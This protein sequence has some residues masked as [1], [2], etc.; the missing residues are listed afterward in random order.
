MNFEYTPPQTQLEELLGGHRC[1]NIFGPIEPGDDERFVS[2]L[3]QSEIPPRTDVYI[4]SSGGDVEAALNIG[5]II[6][7]GWLS[8][9]VGQYVLDQ[10][11]PSDP[12]TEHLKPRRFVVGSC[13]SS[14]TL[15]FLGGRLRYLADGSKF[16]VHQFSFKNP[17]GDNVARSQILSS[18]IARF[19]SDMGIDTRFLEI[20]SSTESIGIR[21]ISYSDLSDLNIVTGGETDVIWSIIARNKII[22][23]RGERDSVYGHQ[24]IIIGFAKGAGFFIHAVIESQGREEELLA[25]PFVE[26]VVGMS[27]KR[28]IDV[29]SLSERDIHGIYTNVVAPISNADA[30]EICNSDGF[31]LRL[32]W[33]LEAPVFLGVAPM[34][35][36]TGGDILRSFVHVHS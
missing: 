2:F 18:K 13:M 35:T 19:V 33:T 7:E 14:A 21:L 26:V 16:G 25:M 32:R 31:G 34:S 4:H 36:A 30:M 29:S 11:G 5:R 23:V 27:E 17:S 24:K 22:Y 15:I 6:R 3:N 12:L 1:V 9:H 28:S 20:S 10:S 8:T